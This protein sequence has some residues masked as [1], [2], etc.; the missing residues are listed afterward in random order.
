[1]KTNLTATF[2][3]V[4]KN[5]KLPL[6]FLLGLLLGG[7][8]SQPTSAERFLFDVKT[9]EVAHVSLTTNTVGGITHVASQTNIAQEVI[10]TIKPTV[11][12]VTN[13]GASVVDQLFPGLGKLALI[14]LTS[15]LGVFGYSRSKKLS[16]AL[17]ESSTHSTRADNLNIVA[18]TLTQS[19]E[20]FREVLKQTP[21]G[22]ALN[23]KLTDMLQRNQISAGIITEVAQIVSAT[24]DNDKA[25][26]AANAILATLPTPTA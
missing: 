22:Q 24:V 2:F 7:C 8:S 1:M 10:W 25:K 16:A 17:D 21:Q 12:S 5:C 26:R 23:V 19:L 14:I 4:A 3:C 11:T 20:V 18:E 6:G 9:N 13:I 15:I